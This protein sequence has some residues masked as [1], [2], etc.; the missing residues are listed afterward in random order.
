MVAFKP[1]TLA[2][3]LPT[4]CPQKAYDITF[5]INSTELPG[6][7]AQLYALLRAVP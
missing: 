3:P 7:L 1:S 2:L 5:R 6:E 4:A